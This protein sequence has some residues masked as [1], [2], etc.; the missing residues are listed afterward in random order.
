MEAWSAA[1]KSLRR[2]LAAAAGHEKLHRRTLGAQS[3][4]CN[5][6]AAAAD[7]SEQELKRAVRTAE[8]TIEQFTASV[9]VLCRV[10]PSIMKAA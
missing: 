6:V 1:H 10:Q 2:Q 3:K 8:L 7:R 5:K 9:Q 4:S